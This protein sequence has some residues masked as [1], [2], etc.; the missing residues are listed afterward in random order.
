MVMPLWLRRLRA[1]FRYRHFAE[2]VEAEL[3]LHRELTEETLTPSEQVVDRPH[4]RVTR[5]MGN[6]L[7]ARE[8]ARAVWVAP[9]FEH[10]IQDLQF[11]ARQ[12]RA[13][14]IFAATAIGLSGVGIGALVAV[15]TIVNAVLFTPLPYP[16]SNRML[17]AST[18]EGGSVDGM[19]YH[20]IRARAA[21]VLTAAVVQRSGW[22][23]VAGDHAEF[24]NALRVS[25]SYFEVIG[26]A[27]RLGRALAGGDETTIAAAEVVISDALW[28]RAGSPADVV[29]Q[30]WLLGGRAHEVVG[31]MPPTLAIVPAVEVWLPLQV[32]PNDNALNYALLA[33]LKPGAA[34]NTATSVLELVKA[35][36]LAKAEAGSTTRIRSLLWMSLEEYT[37]RQLTVP[38]TLLLLAMASIVAVICAN[39]GGLQLF[40]MIARRRELA[41]RLAVGGGRARLLTQLLTES[42]ALASL[43]GIVGVASAAAAIPVMTRQLP[44]EIL[45][46][47]PLSIDIRVLAAAVLSTIVVSM[48]FGVA[49]ILETRR[50]DLRSILVDGQRSAGSRSR[51]WGRRVLIVGELAATLALLVLSGMLVQAMTAMY[52]A[53]PGFDAR[54]V[55]VAK[56][57]LQGLLVEDSARTATFIERTRQSLSGIPGVESVAVANHAPVERGLNLALAPPSNS[58]V[59]QTRAVDWRSVTPE[60]F[61]VLRIALR[62]GR[63]FGDADGAGGMPV[64]IV[65]ESFASRYFGAEPAIGR[66]LELVPQ[67]R[68]PSRE[69]VGVVADVRS[70][71]GTG[72]TRGFSAM[73]AEAPPTIYVPMAQVPAQLMTLAQRFF[74]MTWL[75]RTTS[76]IPGLTQTIEAEMRRIDQSVAVSRVTTMEQVI[77]DDI[78]GTRI[79]ASAVS[80]FAA[81]AL[82]VATIGIYGVVAYGTSQRSRETAV[83]VALGASRASLL[84]NL[85]GET[86]ALGLVGSLLGLGL[87]MA[88]SRLMTAMLGP[89]GAIDAV[90]TT[91]AVGT[92]VSVV[93]FASLVPAAKAANADPLKALRGD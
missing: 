68:D 9:L 87:V 23:V 93:A 53:E 2:D 92:M 13:A 82:I 12:L 39:L 24:V 70:R 1:R 91:I 22:N 30:Q 5:I 51:N 83:R 55:A 18:P 4:T 88:G 31:V 86:A 11:F 80:I 25:P 67:G 29:G 85:L 3:R 65:N 62:G 44:P 38:L 16:D 72:W 64:A 79:L 47:R 14:P 33:R 75:V 84:G 60:Y 19:T 69:I 81:L 56:V 89:L 45:M 26:V 61:K 71:P 74:P 54:N 43:G 40:R 15:F 28:K 49:P 46:G 78:A 58:R 76:S 90:V 35:D 42:I 34:L 10:L 27:P 52:R 41:T 7:R 20:A 77:E 48:F 6:E 32:T 59:T 50:L 36:L 57:S 73:G 63:E 8:D 37:G 17:V 66:Y 21:D